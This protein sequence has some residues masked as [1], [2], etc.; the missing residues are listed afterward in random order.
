MY[1]VVTQTDF[2][3]LGFNT[4]G[5][6][7]DTSTFRYYEVAGGSH[8]TVHINVELIPAGIFGPNP[9]FLQDLC[10][11]P[12]NTTADA[13]VFVS[14]TLNALW[15]RMTEQVDSGSAPPAGQVMD[16]IAV[17]LGRDAQG[18]VTGGVRLPSM[19]APLAK[20]VSTSVAD[21]NLPPALQG[22]GGLACRL[23][24]SVEAF[25]QATLDALYPDHGAYVSAVA[26][27]ANAL[28]QQGLLLQQDAS[29][30]KKAAAKSAIGK[31]D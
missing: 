4:F 12:L 14:Y 27:S 28:K 13:P 9:I 21:P 30:V 3:E 24:G 11:E 6:Q 25:D 10:S 22:I 20:Y 19:E 1:Q 23:S 17:V 31:T 2:E 15:E 7:S 5:R 18:N 8:N 29:R 26:T 16:Q